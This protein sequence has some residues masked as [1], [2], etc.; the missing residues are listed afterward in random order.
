MKF[1]ERDIINNLRELSNI[2][3]L[4]EIY[5]SNIS[6]PAFL[7]QKDLFISNIHKIIH[8]LYEFRKS[9]NL[10]LNIQNIS[11]I[12]DY[13]CKISKNNNNLESEIAHRSQKLYQFLTNYIIPRQDSLLIDRIKSEITDMKYELLDH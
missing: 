10:D 13:F 7:I 6:N 1:N 5:A 8:Q 9:G 11:D 12:N 2:T 3:D 4:L